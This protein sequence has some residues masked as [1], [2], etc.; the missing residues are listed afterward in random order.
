MGE[1]KGKAYIQIVM[2][3]CILVI[4]RIRMQMD[5]E[6]LF[7]LMEIPILADLKMTILMARELIRQQTVIHT[8]ANGNAEREM[9]MAQ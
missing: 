8:L 6:P 1:L 5:K 3:P 9:V 7:G 2:G 4:L